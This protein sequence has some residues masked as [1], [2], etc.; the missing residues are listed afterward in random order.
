[1]SHSLESL[2]RDSVLE[3]PRTTLITDLLSFLLVG[4]VA[5]IGYVGLST[6]MISLHLGPPDWVMSALCYTAFILPVYLAHRHVS[7]RSPLPHKVAL[8]RYIAVQVSALALAALFS[9][10]CYAVLGMET[11]VAGLAVI[12]LTSGVNFFVLR[13][14][15]F[16]SGR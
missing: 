7:F 16:A 6:F 4:S 8:P 1:M 10:V 15:A 12:C 11:A 14:W 13:L 2:M 5:A 9:Y 3:Q